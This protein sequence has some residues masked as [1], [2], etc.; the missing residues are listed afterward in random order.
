MKLKLF[1]LLSLAISFNC[2]A[3]ASI[4]SIQ[5]LASKAPNIS[6]IKASTGFE[7]LYTEETESGLTRV[8]IGSYSNRIEAMKD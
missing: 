7:E 3:D 6:S 1:F 2:F 4:F 8:K 5:I